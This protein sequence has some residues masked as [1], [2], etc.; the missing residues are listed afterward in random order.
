[1]IFTFYS[2]KGGVGRSMALANVAQWLY[3]Q[4]LRVVM[5]DWDLEAPGLENF[6]YASSDDL[7]RVRSQ[8]GVIDILTAYQREF[9]H[10][11]LDAEGTSYERMSVAIREHLPALRDFLHTIRKPGELPNHPSAGIWLLPSGWRAAD[12]F[13]AYAE[14]VQSFD[15]LDFYQR[16]HGKEYL[17]WFRKTI[18]TPGV[19]DVVLIDSRTGVT[20]MGGVCTR[21]LADVVVAFCA[22]NLGNLTGTVTI[23]SSFQRDRLLEARSFRPIQTLIVP[24]RIENTELERKNAFKVQFEA[25]VQEFTPPTFRDSNRTFWSLQIPYVPHYAYREALVVGV[26]GGDEHLEAAYKNLT[27]HLAALAPADSAIH[28][29]CEAELLR[30][31]SWNQ[32]LKN[33]PGLSAA[34]AVTLTTQ[35]ANRVFEA[36]SLDDR[37]AALRLFSR[38]VRVEAARTADGQ[39]P[40]RV[41]HLPLDAAAVLQRFVDTGLLSLST[42]AGSSDR[43]I[44]A[45]DQFPVASWQPVREWISTHRD[46]L[47]WRQ[48][49]E[50]SVDQWLQTQRDPGALLRGAPLKEAQ[51]IASDPLADLNDLERAY[52]EASSAAEQQATASQQAVEQRERELSRAR[53]RFRSILLAAAAMAALAVLGFALRERTAGYQVARTVDEG[54]QLARRLAALPTQRAGDTTGYDARLVSDWCS[55]MVLAGEYDHARSVADAV[56][57]PVER[58]AALAR[59]ALF[60][61]TANEHEA[62]GQLAATAVTDS[63]G[64]D[65]TNA[66]RAGIAETLLAAGRHKEAAAVAQRAVRGFRASTESYDALLLAQL[67]AVIAMSDISSAVAAANDGIAIA[68]RADAGDAAAVLSEMSVI[69]A[70]TKLQSEALAA[71]VAAVEK[72][73]AAAGEGAAGTRR[74]LQIVAALARASGVLT[75]EKEAQRSASA[76]HQAL[77][78]AARTDDPSE[79]AT[80]YVG[81]G[82]VLARGGLHQEA[83]KAADTGVAAALSLTEQ[84]DKGF[85]I[86]SSILDRAA[87]AL[88]AAGAADKAMQVAK[89]IKNRPKAA[90]TLARIAEQLSEQKSPRLASTAEAAMDAAKQI[91]DAHQKTDV[92]VRLAQVLRRAGQMDQAAEAARAGLKAAADVPDQAEKLLDVVR[93]AIVLRDLGRESEAGQARDVIHAQAQVLRAETRMGGTP[94]KR[95]KAVGLTAEALAGLGEFRSAREL[96]AMAS[97]NE[98]LRAFEEIVFEYSRRRNPTLATSLEQMRQRDGVTR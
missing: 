81:V 15:W 79:R 47:L 31:L 94:Q 17:E 16:Y 80:L 9:P 48:R 72:A 58:P 50:A 21:E 95:S 38:L 96:A 66:A 39:R 75:K 13:S 27:A 29:R 69:L 3:L 42:D 52:V 5:I 41:S 60:L 22:P 34:Q 32:V 40:T 36:L 89:Q 57:S 10:L 55:A 62:A 87:L 53:K 33:V 88:V 92:Y 86:Q 78:L 18:D 11:A 84:Y 51:K 68:R 71:A 56:E 74:H 44:Q 64:L 8:P 2:Y 4:G 23:A 7:E 70:A 49:L 91:E 97:D 26:A 65:D 54:Q 76:L 82:E 14:T 6:F 1:M 98:R 67:A 77:E 93:L 61:A 85:E 12:R 30:L 59:V 73:Q 25:A 20:E 46:F 63:E 24:T 28:Q 83:I 45:A 35:E 37:R 43:L 19:C 90:F